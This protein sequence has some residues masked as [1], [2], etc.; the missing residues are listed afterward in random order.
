MDIKTTHEENNLEGREERSR[1]LARAVLSYF[2]V[3][4]L[5]CTRTV[6]REGF[7]SHSEAAQRRAGASGHR[8]RL[9]PLPHSPSPYRTLSSHF[10]LPSRCC[11]SA[12]QA[13]GRYRQWEEGR[14]QPRL[15]PFKN[16][17]PETSTGHLSGQG[18]L[19]THLKAKGPGKGNNV[20]GR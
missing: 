3:T 14:C 13:R 12:L 19:L 10:P 15:S 6:R 4:A 1:T 18:E 9:A 17:H 7:P 8:P 16:P 2:H 5:G 20:S 11:L